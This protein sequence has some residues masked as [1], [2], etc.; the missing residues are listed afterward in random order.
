MDFF[1]TTM[2]SF[3]LNPIKRLSNTLFNNASQDVDLESAFLQLE[4][5]SNY[6]PAMKFVKPL[7]LSHLA[8]EPIRSMKLDKAIGSAQRM[9][10]EIN[11]LEKLDNCNPYTAKHLSSKG[12]NTSNILSIW[13]ASCGPLIRI[14]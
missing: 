13:P 14:S 3:H 4:K 11:D 7:D 8:A 9:A 12:S 6:L 2:F 1:S 10:E 5:M